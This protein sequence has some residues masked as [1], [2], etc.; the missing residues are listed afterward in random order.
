M[1]SS[2][3]LFSKKNFL[4]ISIISLIAFFQPFCAG[5][6][7]S[8]EIKYRYNV[9]KEDLQKDRDQKILNR[10]P[11][12]YMTVDEYEKASEY[13]DKSELEFDVPKIETPSD[14]KYI[15]KPLYRIVKY[16]S[17]PGK[18]ELSLGRRLFVNKQINAQGIVSPDYTKLV[19]PA[20]YYYQDTASVAADLFVIPLTGDDTN[21]VKIQKANIAKRDPNPILS[22]DKALDN[23]MAFRTLTP[24]DFSPEGDKLLVKEK[25]G[26][27]EDG[28]WA[29]KIYIYD[30]NNKA[31]YDISVIREAI[32]YFWQEYMKLNLDAKRWDILPLGFDAN[33][34]NRVI[35][36]GYAYTGERPVYLGAWSIDV[37]GEQSRLVSFDKDF[38]PQISSN[39][40]KLIKDG[41]ESYTTVQTNEK[42]NKKQDK[43]ILKQ[44]KTKD[45]ET[46]RAIK[47]DYKY[48]L[49]ELRADFKDE[50]RDNKKLHSIKG[51]TETND[52]LPV[53]EQYL[54]DQLQKDIKKT[55]KQIL[56]E[57]KKIDK[58]NAKIQT[59]TDETENLLK[60][61]LK[62]IYDFGNST[63]QD[64]ENTENFEN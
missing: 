27:S 11:S 13:K 43:V 2:K 29:T 23:Y 56:R 26:S 20:I 32:S 53:Y 51:S 58:S 60:N 24:V 10:H 44:R 63:S 62:N 59:L 5:E 15:P 21:L 38:E 36:Q 50:Y 49:K 7:T 12:G 37:K 14:F 19:Y 3:M 64:E 57:Q 22:T 42:M 8:K 16:N 48:E 9:L 35:V 41:V 46:V 1:V 54:Q 52:I 45:K 25:L 18:T 55:E 4:V 17:P 47:E 30:F 31:S 6:Y 40:Y 28:I 34:S 61:D 39:G 33:D